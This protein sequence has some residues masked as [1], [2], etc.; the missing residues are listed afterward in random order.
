MWTNST[1]HYSLTGPVRVHTEPRFVT[2]TCHRYLACKRSHTLS[3]LIT[4]RIF[5]CQRD[6]SYYGVYNR[7]K[8]GSHVGRYGHSLTYGTGLNTFS[9]F[10]H[11][12]HT[13]Y[14]HSFDC[15]DTLVRNCS[16]YMFFKTLL[17]SFVSH[18]LGHWI[19]TK[20][21]LYYGTFEHSSKHLMQ[22]FTH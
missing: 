19:R 22:I 8:H 17:T 6:I 15:H 7:H 18:G 20:I 3:S 1:R 12:F 14:G 21:A 9:V 2:L 4:Y 16:R 11:V 13:R 5:P 10:S